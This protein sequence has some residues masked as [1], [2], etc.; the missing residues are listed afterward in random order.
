MMKTALVA[1]LLAFAASAC[2]S[3][4]PAENA[5]DGTDALSDDTSPQARSSKSI[6]LLFDAIKAAQ[7]Q[8]IASMP[9]AGTRLHRCHSK[10]TRRRL[11]V[12]VYIPK[13]TGEDAPGVVVFRG[14]DVTFGTYATIN[15]G[16]DSGTT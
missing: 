5:D 16:K 14:K 6:D 3:S 9:P 13:D 4:A 7:T 8:G 15:L 12:D 10:G 2:G 11:S 1:W